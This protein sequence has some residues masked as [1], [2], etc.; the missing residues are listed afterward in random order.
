M[1][2]MA[3]I[4]L[5]LLGASAGA[6][7]RP[8][9]FA[10]R[11]ELVR[12]SL[13]VVLA[14]AVLDARYV[15]IG[16]DHLTREI[17]QFTTDLC[18]MMAPKGLAV[19]AVETGPEAAQVVN[20]ILRRPDRRNRLAA[21]MHTHPDAMAFQNGRDESDM[22]ASCAQAAGLEFQLWGLDQE[23]FGAAGNLLDRM[24]SAHPGPVARAAAVA[25]RS[26]A[27]S[28]MIAARATGPG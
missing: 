22:A 12:P 20:T 6:A 3:G 7:D 17:P 4:V 26:A 25:L 8:P 1:A 2:I 16:E 13:E 9:T 19:L 15:L 28:R 21:F 23:F 10:E 5:T 27:A 11:L 18:R 14:E 24:A